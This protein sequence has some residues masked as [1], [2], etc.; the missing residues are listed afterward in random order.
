MATSAWTSQNARMIGRHNV[1]RE[2]KEVTAVTIT[3]ND[4]RQ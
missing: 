1:M 4:E 3:L 2:E